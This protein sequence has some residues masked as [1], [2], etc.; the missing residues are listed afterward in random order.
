MNASTL[1]TLYALCQTMAG[2]C[3]FA[4]A[5]ARSVCGYHSEILQ[6]LA[7]HWETLACA[8]VSETVDG[9]LHETADAGIILP[10]V[11]QAVDDMMGDASDIFGRVLETLENAYVHLSFPDEEMPSTLAFL[12]NIVAR[13]RFLLAAMRE[14]LENG[15][16]DGEGPWLCGECGH[17]TEEL[18]DGE[19]CPCCGKSLSGYRSPSMLLEFLFRTDG[20]EN[21]PSSSLPD[22]DE[23]DIVSS[24]PPEE[25]ELSDFS[26]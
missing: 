12:P 21:A 10:V 11:T 9:I 22:E 20:D 6:R 15:L 1:G 13:H 17:M 5:S 19:T 18:P 4:A 2:N 16:F 25:D 8:L 3:T 23:E 24:T 26:G 7:A 14:R